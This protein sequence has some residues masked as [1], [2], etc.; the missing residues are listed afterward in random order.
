MCKAMSETYSQIVD[1]QNEYLVEVDE[2][3]K[4]VEALQ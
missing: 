1:D 3:M 2:D 4:E